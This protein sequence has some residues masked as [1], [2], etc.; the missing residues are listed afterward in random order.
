MPPRDRRALLLQSQSFNG[1]DFVE[2]ADDDQ[3]SLRVHFLNQVRPA[4]A[5]AVT[6]T[7]GESIPTVAVNPIDDATAWSL[8]GAH[9][10]LSLTVTAPGDFS[11]YT[12][13]L[14]SSRDDSGLD[15]Y[16]ASAVFSFKARCPSDLD[17]QTPPVQCPVPPADAPPIDYLA[18]DFLSFRQALLDFS[19][20]RYPEW[21]ERSEADFGVMF[22]EALSAL[23]DD[24]SYTQDRIAAEAA[25]ETATQRRSLVR[26]ARLV[27]YEPRPATAATVLLQFDVAPGATLHDGLVVSA[28]GPDGTPI[29]FETG[30][31]LLN[32]LYDP[33]TKLQ[34][35]PSSRPTARVNPAWNRGVIRPYWFDDGQRC[36]R[37]GATEM[38]VLGQGFDFFADQ[39]LLI[40]TQAQGA[41]EPPL[42]QIVRLLEPADTDRLCDP[43]Y[44]P[45]TSEELGGAAPP[46]LACP[47]TPQGTAVTLIRWRAEDALTADRDLTRTTLAGNLVVAT[48]ARTQEEEED[49]VIPP[50]PP[51]DVP[52]ALVRTGPNDAPGAAS[53]Q[54]LYPLQAAPL[55]WLQP[56]DAT[57][58]PLPE[59]V[60]TVPAPDGEQVLWEFQ[61]WLLDAAPVD[62]AYTV[63]PAR[64]SRTGGTTTDPRH[65]YD[66]DAGAT[67][68]FGD[69]VFGAVPIPENQ[70][71]VKYRVGGGAAGNV[72]ADSI[73]FVDPTVKGV[74][75]V[76]NPLRAEG[77][78]DAETAE[79]VRR[80]APQAFRA[81]PVRAVLPAD[82]EAAAETLPWVQRAGTVFR[83]TGSWLT[84]FTT[85]DPHQGQPITVEKRTKLIDLLN[86][87]RLAGYESYVPDPRYVSLDV[88]VEVCAQPDA[89]Q[90]DVRQA[91]RAAL[92]A[93]PGGFFNHDNFTSGQPLQL[94]ALETA[95]QRANGVAGVTCVTYRIRGRTNGFLR[96]GDTVAVGADELIRCDNDPSLPEHGSL[97]VVI[98]GGK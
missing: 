78:A 96:M 14:T 31:T 60:L 30:T 49:F 19:A 61:R 64:Y 34:R 63:D 44:P 38:Y 9:L 36:L 81:V 23:A 95:V 43:L 42:R 3:T 76:S 52:R 80:L 37:A 16:F 73:T 83:W 94:S 74:L 47:G 57:Q 84:V 33:D 65:D 5:L 53:L 10:V 54:Y 56:S 58:R 41:A 21:Q 11:N 27:D 26:L 28:R 55:A 86:R 85:P 77:G 88:R 87:R 72:A 25:L 97:Q 6:I 70:F 32:R 50:A 7:G 51:S 15:P 1:I 17:C 59:V 46:V 82:Y 45:P 89:F 13:T 62:A 71:T 12:L 18:K 93:A 39:R 8:D 75:R 2:M 67:L 48:Q 24:L 90:S 35:P 66:G 4:G 91:V 98:R 22:L 68:R 20:R 29:P 79:S 69:G 40:E 92:R